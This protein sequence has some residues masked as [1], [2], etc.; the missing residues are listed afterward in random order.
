M[1]CE[2]WFWWVKHRDSEFYV[3]EKRYSFWLIHQEGCN[4]RMRRLRLKAAFGLAWSELVE[5]CVSWPVFS[6]IAPIA[7]W[8][9]QSLL[10]PRTP[11]WYPQR[12]TVLLQLNDNTW[13]FSIFIIMP[14]RTPRK[15]RNN[16]V[17]DSSLEKKKVPNI[18]SW[19][20]KGKSP[21]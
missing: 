6:S 21:E 15:P 1:R 18:S 8:S 7:I 9:A 3:L 10:L 11:S 14:L 13:Y 2:L 20:L 16:C 5:P 4:K 17:H 19:N 12:T